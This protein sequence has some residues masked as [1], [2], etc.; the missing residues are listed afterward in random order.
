MNR[1]S[2]IAIDGP[3][4]SGKSTLAHALANK[5]GY[6]YLDTGVMYRAVTLA[7]LRSGIDLADEPALTR[8]A[9]T[10]EI[11]VVAPTVADGRD[12]TIYL[13]GEDV[14]L[15][16]RE[17]EV[18]AGVSIPS[19]YAGVRQALSQK[20]R[21]I[22]ERRRVVMAGRDIGTVVMP[23]ADLKIYLDASAEA[24]ARRR[25]LELQAG[26]RSDSYDDILAGV[27]RRDEIDSRRAVAPLRPADDAIILDTTEMDAPAV[28]DYVMGLVGI[29]GDDTEA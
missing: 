23:D 27:R 18:D 1:P 29:A 7:A 9:E 28:L 17:A 4:A 21:R 22:G 24:R 5:L 8:L 10:V 15:G 14:T 2:T 20:Q 3:A 12:C 6:L 26:N 16:L 13:D 25:W 11:D 19:A